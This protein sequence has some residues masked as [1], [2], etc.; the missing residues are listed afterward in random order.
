MP[1]KKNAQTQE[2][3]EAQVKDTVFSEA[4]AAQGAASQVKIPD[5]VAELFRA[6]IKVAMAQRK[7]YGISTTLTSLARAVA[8]AL[9]KY[10][11]GIPMA[12]LRE[13]I[14]REVAAWGY[15]VTEAKVSYNGVPY[16]AE[17]VFL[18]RS[19][20]EIVEMIRN[21]RAETFKPVITLDG[22]DPMFD[23]SASGSGK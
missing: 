21:G 2:G 1:K 3:L 11:D 15:L 8:K 7:V 5:E 6:T 4:G 9:D 10:V 16:I 22:I 19:F 14:K 18:Y 23:K 17:T 20:D 13:F 12:V